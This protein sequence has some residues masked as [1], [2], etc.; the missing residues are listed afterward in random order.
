MVGQFHGSSLTM[1]SARAHA[2]SARLELLFIF[3]VDTIIAVIL[4]RMIRVSANG[5]QKRAGKNLQLLIA[6]IHRSAIAVVWQSAGK[7]SYD[8]VCCLRIVLGAV[9]VGDFQNIASI[10]YQSILKAPSCS[11]EWP[12]PLAR[13]LDAAQHSI[14]T[15][16]R[17]PWRSD[18]SV[19]APQDLVPIG[20]SQRRSWQPAQFDWN[21]QLGRRVV[22]GRIGRKVRV[23]GWFKVSDNA[24]TNLLSHMSPRSGWFAVPN[25]RQKVEVS[26]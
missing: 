1:D 20:V 5:M 26:S 25:S 9:G 18:Q 3:F 8:I 2:Q 7:R 22:D 21:P 4:L 13:E 12:I 19:P 24:D 11:H 14:E 23:I 6:G 16:V 10:L 17:T 15:L